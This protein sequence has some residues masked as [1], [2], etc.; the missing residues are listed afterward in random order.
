MVKWAGVFV[1]IFFMFLSCSKPRRGCM[2]PSAINFDPSASSA[3]ATCQYNSFYVRF[4]YMWDGAPFEANRIYSLDSTF[5]AIKT[6]QCYFSNLILEDTVGT[7]YHLSPKYLSLFQDQ[8]TY[9][10][11]NI[12]I[13][14]LEK[15]SINFGLDP[16][17]NDQVNQLINESGHPLEEVS[18]ESMHWTNGEGFIFLKIKGNVDKNGD[19]IPNGNETFNYEIGTDQ[20]FQSLVFN[21]SPEWLSINDTIYCHIEVSNLFNTI[22]F[23]LEDQTNSIDDPNLALRIRDNFTGSISISK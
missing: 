1:L 9:F 18:P 11:K 3:N 16:S 21:M 2:D 22:D 4:Q 7:T 17:T 12:P 15:F 20:L 5:L 14:Y 10:F 6:I 23:Q 19:G 8:S 13:R